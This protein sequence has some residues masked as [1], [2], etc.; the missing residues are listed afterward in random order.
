M[1]ASG[2]KMITSFVGGSK[3]W[4]IA[5]A[6]VAAVTFGIGYASGTRTITRINAK[7][8]ASA[9]DRAAAAQ[10]AHDRQQLEAAQ[11]DTEARRKAQAASTEAAQVIYRDRTK[12]V[13]VPEACREAATVP[14]DA[15]RRLND[16]KLLGGAE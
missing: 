11:K 14:A 2:W 9:Q 10:A 7:E 12:I 8:L 6:L 16:P 1:I 3:A 15:M 4:L 5:I 13:R